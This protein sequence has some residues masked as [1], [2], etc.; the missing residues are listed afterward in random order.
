MSDAKLMNTITSLTNSQLAP[1]ANRRRLNM[2]VFVWVGG[3]LREI[4]F[5]SKE[6]RSG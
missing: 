1:C 6:N 2:S 3:R 5:V 4:M